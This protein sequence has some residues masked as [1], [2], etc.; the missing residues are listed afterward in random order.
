MKDRQTGIKWLFTIL[1]AIFLMGIFIGSSA[2][3]IMKQDAP[4]KY[5][6]E[7]LISIKLQGPE[8]IVAPAGPSGR[9]IG[10]NCTTPIVVNI[11]GS[12][13]YSD[14]GNTTCGRGNTYS[15]SD[16][17]SYDG[18]EDIIYQLNVSSTTE[19]IITMNPRS[20]TWTGLGLFTSCPTTLGNSLAVVTGLTAAP[21]VIQTALA[22][23]TYYVMA[24]TW[25]TPN[26]ISTLDLS[27]VKV[28][29]PEP[30]VVPFCEN[31]TGIIAGNLPAGWT[32]GRTNWGVNLTNF[33]GGTSPEMRLNYSPTFT[34]TTILKSKVID[35]TAANPLVDNL[36]LTFNHSINH[37]ATPYTL[38]VMASLDGATWN[39][40]Y[41]WSP[42]SNIGPEML[43]LD[44]GKIYSGQSFYI[45]FQF[46]GYSFNIN[47]WYIDDICLTVNHATP[48][49]DWAVYIGIFLILA[50]AVIRF[51]KL[52]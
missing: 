44:L 2:Q 19:V 5:T 36:Y 22:P 40:L 9:A 16:L 38:S 42:T 45:G 41:T 7:E 12:L 13:P 47:Y 18:G 4:R 34:G 21:R 48:L 30:Y 52:L 10:D 39:T 43:T 49:T 25:P 29:P 33:A 8:V 31:F 35:A 26:C 51:R 28:V 6:E 1:M 24:D 11:P 37:Y 23:G 46:S 3:N 20:T 50:V 14:I 32:S 27:I 17:G 15:N